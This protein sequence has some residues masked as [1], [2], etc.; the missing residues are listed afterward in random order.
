MKKIFSM[1]MALT[2]TVA[3][4]AVVVESLV[5]K[6]GTVLHGYIQKQNGDLCTFLS[7]NA[8]VILNNKD[9][10]G[11]SNERAYRISELNDAWKQWAEKNDAFEGLGDNR[12]LTLCDVT[13]KDRTAGMVKVLER[14]ATIKYLEMTPTTYI[15]SWEKE[16][17][18]KR[19]ERRKKTALSGINVKYQL[20]SGMEYQG[21]FAEDADSTL[22]VYLDNG[23]MQTFK[24]ADVVK[25]SY[26]PINPNQTIFEQ[27]P[28]LDVVRTKHGENVGVIIEENYASNKDEE[29]YLLLQQQTG[30]IQS[31]K[32]SE[33]V[34]TR[35]QLNPA[36]DPKFDI[37]LKDGDLVID[38][39]ETLKVTIKEQNDE[40]MLDSLP[41]K[42]IELKRSTDNATHLT[43]EFRNDRL[44]S[45]TSPY[46][47]VKLQTRKGK[48]DLKQHFFTYKDLVNAVYR[49]LRMETSVNHTTKMEFVVGGKGLFVLYDAEKKKGIP[50]S[51][52]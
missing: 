10:V 6:N 50:F 41:S 48:K 26:Y 37:L 32:M 1:F 7:D 43:V 11:I 3:A 15:V 9:V 36:Y 44:A 52:K 51:V 13:T 24:T 4:Q 22:S 17:R 39:Q 20:K 8:L 18:M 19:G 14:G 29:N 25:Y 35:K 45:G 23:V 47:L 33:L 27:S 21:Q 2:M 31:I 49:P 46:Q 38:R 34:E 12:T 30:A 28:L 5:L 16:V 42:I 40:L